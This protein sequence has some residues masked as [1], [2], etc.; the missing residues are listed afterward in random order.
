MAFRLLTGAV[1]PRLLFV[2]S[3]GRVPREYQR[4]SHRAGGGTG[5]GVK[6]GID[7]AIT[8]KHQVAVRE[9]A[10]DGSVSTQ[11][12]AVS[13]TLAGLS[14]LSTRLAR[15]PGVVAVAEPTS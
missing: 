5:R 10:A 11:R 12:F 13:P 7:A 2:S 9:T 3:E 14:V 4:Y 1:T 6:V 15:C 8:A